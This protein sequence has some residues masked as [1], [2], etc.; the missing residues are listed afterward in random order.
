MSRDDYILQCLDWYFSV[1]DLIIEYFK[2]HTNAD[3]SI[4]K[5]TWHITK[6]R[7]LQFLKEHKDYIFRN[8]AMYSYYEAI[9]T[10]FQFIDDN[11]ES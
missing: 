1:S 11:F 10:N 7:L 3:F 2:R 4:A 6:S 8:E 5:E 9:S